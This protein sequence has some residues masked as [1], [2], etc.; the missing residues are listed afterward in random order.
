MLPRPGVASRVH[1]A[2]A[3][4][5]IVTLIGPRQCGKT[6]LA[7]GIASE[8][9][10][11]IIDLEDPSGRRR[12]AQPMAAL[13]PL[14][15]LVVIDEVQL[16]PEVMP[17]L[18]VLADRRPLPARFLLLGSASPDLVRGTSETLA[19]RVAF[20]EMGGFDLSE[21]GPGALRRLWLRGGLPR[22]YLARSDAASRAWRDDFVTTF[23][24]RDLR[25][26]G[27][28]VAPEALRRLWSM[29][30][31]YHGQIWNAS[32]VA[33]SI[34]IAHTT[35]Q[36]HLDVLT[37]ALVVRQLRPWF[38]NLGKR[39]VKSPKIYVRDSGLLHALLGLSRFAELEGSPRLGASWE[40][41]AVEEIA[42]LVGARDVY[43]WATQGG[44]E[45]DLLVLAGGKRWG[46]ELKYADA[47]A[48]TKSM[49]V[50]MGD[51]GLERL[52]VVHPGKERYALDARIDAVGV[53]ELRSTLA[54]VGIG[55]QRKPRRRDDR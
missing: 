39:L 45:L 7:R 11:Q 10:S 49:R 20:V 19:G 48:V 28:E 27:I 51:L 22:S 38:E 30:A 42:R 31:H 16:A 44:A 1:A 24:E 35:V 29:V 55:R 23:L 2:L 21:V 17:I 9:R 12:L 33:R 43:F 52:F 3:T 53:A 5:P 13:A 34:G 26:F 25:R 47:P 14:R 50:A 18:R 37:G 32:E 41:F 6:T 4:S 8:R 15:G 36:R 46:I 40:G 54:A